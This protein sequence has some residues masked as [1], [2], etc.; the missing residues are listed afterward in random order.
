MELR[1]I[2]LAV[3][4]YIAADR[5]QKK[6]WVS[7]QRQEGSISPAVPTPSPW[8]C[9]LEEELPYLPVT[10]LG[11]QVAAKDASLFH[12]S[13][14]LPGATVGPNRALLGCHVVHD[15]VRRA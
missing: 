13:S 5:N 14:E 15:S 9:S 11:Q 12:Q 7:F 3:C 10:H 2:R 6:N 8:I 1:T 4:M